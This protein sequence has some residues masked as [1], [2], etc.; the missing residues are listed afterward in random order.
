MPETHNMNTKCILTAS[1]IFLGICGISFSFLPQEILHTVISKSEPALALPLQITG[2]LFIALTIINW[3]SR[4][5]LMGG[6]YN[7]PLALGNALH[8]GVGAITLIKFVIQN[9]PTLS[10]IIITVLY[11]MFAIAFF[12]VIFTTPKQVSTS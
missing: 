10:L 8:F 2:S 11:T 9:T 3:M 1:A 5:N 4:A 7:R 12:K 6:I